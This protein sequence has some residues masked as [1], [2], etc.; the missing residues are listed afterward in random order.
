MKKKILISLIV[1]CLTNCVK[2]QNF[3]VN[4]WLHDEVDMPKYV[5]DPSAHA[6]VLNE[7]ADARL[8]NTESDGSIRLV[9]KYHVKIKIFDESGIKYGTIEIPLYNNNEVA[10]EVSEIDGLT[11][12]KDNN[13]VVKTEKLDPAKIYRVRENKNYSTAKFAMPGVKNGAI[14]EYSYTIVSPYFESFRT[15]HFQTGIPKVHSKYEAHIPGFWTYNISIRG[16]LKMTS[17]TATL[18]RDCF[19]SHGAKSDCSHLVF[20]M[21]NIPAF[22]QEDYMT[23]PKN[24]M[25]AIYFELSAFTNPYTGTVNKLAKQWSDVDYQL[26]HD[27]NF[28]SQIKRKDLLKDRILPIIAGKTN[29][30]DKAKAVYAYIQKTI[31]WNDYYS[32]GSSNDG[33][34]KA[35]D[36]HTGTIGDI[37]LSLISALNAAGLT[38]EAVIL[39]TRDHGIINKLYP[40]ITEFDYV[41]AKVT[42][43]DKSYL[44]D[45]TDPLLSFGMLPL[46]CLNDQGRVMSLSKPSYWMDITTPQKENRIYTLDLTLQDNGKLKGTFTIY[47]KGY[48]GFKVRKAIKKFNSIDEYVENLDEKLT[49]VKILKSEVTNVDSLDLAVSEKYEIEM[50]AYNDLNHQKLSFNPYL[51]DRVINNPFKLTERLYPVDWGMPSETRFVLQMHLPD[52]YVVEDPPQNIAIGLPNQGGSFMVNYEPGENSFTFS[53]II[54]FKKSIYLSEEYSY[55]KELYNK[56]ILSEKTEMIFKKKQ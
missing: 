49:K 55:L 35:L 20:E 8:D 31:K 2:A 6:V 38:P 56:I 26:K 33:I 51:F 24:F 4:V 21:A 45:A 44:L 50:D 1:I 19:T 53:H 11:A 7:Y 12:Y 40:V 47:S 13:G 10:E 37:N 28:G 18:E 17:N 9:Y 48:A 27:D 42:I 36:N 25:S 32:L 22:I 46:R 52:K 3:P 54:S 5:N 29:E 30:L 14:I 16:D 43:D 39:S 41:I 23:A 15:W 34:R